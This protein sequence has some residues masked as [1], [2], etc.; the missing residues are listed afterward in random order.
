MNMTPEK[1]EHHATLLCNRVKKRY[2]HLRKRFARR[3]IDCFRLYDW[4]I[5]EVRAVVDWYAGHLVVAEYV[6]TQTGPDWL[7]AMAA[8]LSKAMEISSDRVHIKRRQTKSG[9]GL[10][11]S[12]LAET[13]QRFIVHERD[14]KFW[15][16]CEDFLDTGLFS[17]HRDTRLMVQDL[18][19][20]KRFLNLFAY[21]GA[22]TC[23]AASGGAVNCTTV[24]R[25][26]TYISWA[27]DNL[28]LNGLWNDAHD[29]VQSDVFEFLRQQRKLAKRY[30]LCVVDPPSFFRDD[31]RNVNF[32]VNKDHIRLLENV[33]KVMDQGG[34]VF[35]STNHQKFKSRLRRLDVAQMMELTP[36]SIPEDY[37]NRQIHRC[38]KI[39]V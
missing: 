8:A 16:N 13:N 26:D 23:A 25:S 3:Q 1:I 6:R 37:R 10:R 14:L 28:V 30:D 36:K 35:F 24:D 39:T 4:D 33:I 21:T 22:F 15:I 27:K 9:S 38:W 20:G 31:K 29:L 7:P 17:D 19:E 18:A 5:P 34:I 11:Y 12:R 2:A 32:D